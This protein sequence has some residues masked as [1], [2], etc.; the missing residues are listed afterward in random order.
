MFSAIAALSTCAIAIAS[1]DPN[2]CDEGTMLQVNLAKVR[3]HSSNET[4]RSHS[5]DT[6]EVAVLGCPGSY[7]RTGQPPR[8]VRTGTANVYCC[9]IDGNQCHHPDDCQA[10]TDKTFAEAQDICSSEGFRL[11]TEDEIE[12]RTCCGRGCDFAFHQVWTSPVTKGA[13]TCPGSGLLERDRCWYLSEEGGTCRQACAAQGLEFSWLVAGESS[14]LVPMLL[15]PGSNVRRNGPWGRLECYVPSERR[16]HTAMET[17]R[18]RGR[19]DDVPVEDWSYSICQ[20]ACPCAPPL[21]GDVP[22]RRYIATWL[23]T[24]CPNPE[25]GA[26]AVNWWREVGP[27]RAFADMNHYCN[28]VATGRARSRQI[29]TCCGSGQQ[30][31]PTNCALQTNFA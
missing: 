3:K 15:P 1:G 24:G 8:E 4:Q 5:D 14:P 30:C 10:H 18:N 19:H 29:R 6:P 27:D 16:Y 13:P 12:A 26:W 2:T 22:D 25:P 17:H 31:I 7:A 11:C 23:A 21:S 9:S 28:L 20:M